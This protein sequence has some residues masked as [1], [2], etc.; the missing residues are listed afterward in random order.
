MLIGVGPSSS[1]TLD[2]GE[3][4]KI[5]IKETGRAQLFD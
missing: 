3:G 5:G 4:R 2:L 1:H